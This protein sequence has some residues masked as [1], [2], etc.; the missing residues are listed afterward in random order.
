MALIQAARP[1]G[2]GGGGGGITIT[3]WESEQFTQVSNFIS[4]GVVL[5]LAQTPVV[6]ASIDLDYNGQT[7]YLATSFSVTGN[8]ITILFADPYVTDYDEPPIFHVRY[9]Y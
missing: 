3:G 6:P 7:K 1:P 8:Q 2:N 4:G 9:P 5:T